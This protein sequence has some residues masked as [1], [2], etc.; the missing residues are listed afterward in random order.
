MAKL[1]VGKLVDAA[2]GTDREVTPDVGSG[3]KLDALDGSRGWLEAL[4]WVFGGDTGGNDM[5]VNSL[6]VL[7]QEID[8]VIAVHVGL[9]VELANLGNAVEGDAHG[10]L[11]L[12]RGKVDKG[13]AFGDGVLDL[14]TG[15][16]LEEEEL[17]S[18]R[19]EEVLDSSC[20][21][22]A[23]GLGETLC[24]ALHLLESLRGSNA[25]RSLLENLLETTLGTAVATIQGHSVAVLI[26]D[27]LNLQ[28]T[29]V[30]TELHHENGGADDLVGDLDVG[31]A[32]I[33]LVVNETDS[34]SSSSLT[35]LD[36][37]TVLVTDPRSSLNS[38]LNVTA[39]G[40]LE[41]I[42][43][44]G[45]LRS[46]GSLKGAV[47]W[48]TPAPAPRNGGDLGGLGENVGGNLVAQNRHDGSGRTDKLDTHL[49][50]GTRKLGVLGSVAP[51]GPDGVDTLLLSNLGDDIDVSVVI[52]VLSCWN[53]NE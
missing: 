19:V 11:E 45:A 35:G 46:E 26:A 44:D 7:F 51:S 31:V 30:L 28:M 4:V 21:N 20:S 5:R 32:E 37:Q 42:V 15:V 36:H 2:I 23:N 8:L 13:D 22:V 43:G 49:L 47:S 40:H 53:L 24:G 10:N 41:D 50:Q 34:L 38:L 25:G 17:A 29:G 33:L 52:A 39:G 9:A 27:N 6:V 48:A 18:I 14:E 1:R 16:Q 12:S 3:L